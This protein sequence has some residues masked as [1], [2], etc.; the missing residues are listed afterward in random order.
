MNPPDFLREARADGVVLR[1]IADGVWSALPGGAPSQPYDGRARLYDR[2]IGNRFYNRIAWGTSPAAY[3]AFAGSAAGSGGGT[4]LD[5]GCGTLVSTAAVHARTARPTV[6]VDLSADML[7]A[8]RQRLTAIA[9]RAPPHIAF[10]QADVLHLPFRP[11]AFGAVL[12]PGMV[13]LFEDVEALAGE[14]TRVAAPGASLFLSSLVAD[15]R[16]SALYLGALHRAGEV[17]RPRTSAE[18]LRRLPR[19]AA[20]R[21]EGG[22]AFVTV[23]RALRP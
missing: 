10:V 9:G 19:A 4:L 12:C 13:H 5:V 8:A 2:L 21:I 14:L 15:R 16:L 1:S 11:A 17:A 22:M 20:A 18:L 7:L 23:G 6:L 3:G